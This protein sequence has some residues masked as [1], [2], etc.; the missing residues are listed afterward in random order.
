[1]KKENEKIENFVG[2]WNKIEM[3]D[4]ENLLKQWKV[5]WIARKFA[6]LINPKIF[7]TIENGWYVFKDASKI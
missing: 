7:L 2:V 3:H 1:M 5:N 6:Y 4:M